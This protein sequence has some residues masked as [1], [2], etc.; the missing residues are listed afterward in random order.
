MHWNGSKLRE[1]RVAAEMR[2]LDLAIAA[3]VAQTAISR[4]EAGSEPNGRNLLAIA[5]A[6]GCK[7]E[8]LYDSDLIAV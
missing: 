2:Q 8:A 6:L 1:V 5:K 4:W 7:P 3:G